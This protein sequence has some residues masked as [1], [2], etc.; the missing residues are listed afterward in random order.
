M[1]ILWIYEQIQFQYTS[2]CAYLA[3]LNYYYFVFI[4]YSNRD[5]M[6]SYVS[7]AS[8]RTI[9]FLNKHTHVNPFPI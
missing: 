2:I 6:A 9:V 5:R 1:M 7:G 3:P 8:I 4:T